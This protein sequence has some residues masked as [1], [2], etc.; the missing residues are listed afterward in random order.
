MYLYSVEQSH[1]TLLTCCFFCQVPFASLCTTLVCTVH[2][3]T[4]CC[5]PLNMPGSYAHK[6]ERGLY[7]YLQ[8]ICEYSK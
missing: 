4:E 7:K 1:S 3:I 5:H 2:C 8:K 6:G